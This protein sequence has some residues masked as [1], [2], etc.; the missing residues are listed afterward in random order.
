MSYIACAP[1]T[2]IVANEVTQ[3][4]REC[5]RFCQNPSDCINRSWRVEEQMNAL[6]RLSRYEW[7]VWPLPQYRFIPSSVSLIE[8]NFNRGPVNISG[9]ETENKDEFDGTVVIV[10]RIQQGLES[11]DPIVRRIVS[12]NASI[13]YSP[14]SV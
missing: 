5:T 9:T 6:S 2:Q 7:L 13:L 12:V 8:E 10:I 11:Y 4:S 14:R 1:T 3:D